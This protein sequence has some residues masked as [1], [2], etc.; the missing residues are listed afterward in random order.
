MGGILT[1][2]Y[3]MVSL[4]RNQNNTLT[5]TAYFQGYAV[6]PGVRDGSIKQPLTEVNSNLD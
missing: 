2:Y 6:P 1:D 5:I 4:L 3:R